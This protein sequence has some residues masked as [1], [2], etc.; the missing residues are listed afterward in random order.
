MH[1]GIKH[2]C[3]ITAPYDVVLDITYDWTHF[4]YLHRR[5][6]AEFK[7]L[8]KSDKREVFF[9]K[10]KILPPF[11]FY[12]YYVVF[13]DYQPERGGYRQ[14]YYDLKTGGINYLDAY[15]VKN[16]KTCSSIGEY[17]FEVPGYW[18]LFPGLFARLMKARHHRVVEEDNELVRERLKVDNK[19]SPAC[20]PVVH[21]KFDLFED[22]LKQ[23]IPR[24]DF[25]FDQYFFN[26]LMGQA[27]CQA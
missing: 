22:Y 26:D 13:R 4:L 18:R 1:I 2:E 6:H 19:E 7:L 14:I 21:S 25:A 15:T 3:E 27:A 12:K 20:A 9:Y 8:F 5:S 10:A 23:G 17:V 16:E 24:T 11:P